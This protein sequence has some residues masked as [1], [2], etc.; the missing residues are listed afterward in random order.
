MVG[1]LVGRNTVADPIR[2][3]I[4]AG[5]GRGIKYPTLGCFVKLDC[6]ATLIA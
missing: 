3:D 6:D 4:H 5:C 2:Q 1:K